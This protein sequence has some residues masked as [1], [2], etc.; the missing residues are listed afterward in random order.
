M[1]GTAAAAHDRT[2]FHKDAEARL[3]IKA[4]VRVPTYGEPW[5]FDQ[6]SRCA[7]RT[8]PRTHSPRPATRPDADATHRLGP[9]LSLKNLSTVVMKFITDIGLAI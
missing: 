6:C 5:P 8:S 1:P 3:P 9:A 2:R 7:T 4:D